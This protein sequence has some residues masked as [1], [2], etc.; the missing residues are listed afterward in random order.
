MG[1]NVIIWIKRLN[2]N[3]LW[4]AWMAYWTDIKRE[5]PGI[6]IVV[7]VCVRVCVCV[8]VY[9]GMCCV[10]VPVL[11][12]VSVCLCGIKGWHLDTT[13]ATRRPPH[14]RAC[15]SVYTQPQYTQGLFH[16]TLVTSL[17]N[18]L[19]WNSTDVPF[20]VNCPMRRRE[21][22][23][24]QLFCQHKSGPTLLLEEKRGGPVYLWDND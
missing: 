18:D 1:Y 20:Y 7:Y 21:S 9:G 12:C 13:T 15:V 6:N 2:K 23:W 8:C 10:C 22:D 16:S 19:R 24:P 3:V 11:W 4:M 5:S 14:W 17:P